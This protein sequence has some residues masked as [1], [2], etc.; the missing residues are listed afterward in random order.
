ME[1]LLVFALIAA[2][3][4]GFGAISGRIQKTV[5]TPPM[6]FVVFGLLLGEWG[7]GLVELELESEFVGV[8]AE[9]TLILVL[10]TDASR[11]DLELLRKDHDLPVRLL[12]IGLPLTMIFGTGVALV[13]FS[14]LSIWVAVVLAIILAPTDAA[15]GQA[16]VSSPK[17]PIR[18]RQA[19]NV[20]SGL[21][22][23][24]ALPILLFFLS[25][26][27]AMEAT[28]PINEWIQFGA[29]QI[30]L[31][32]VIGVAVA[33]FGG[34]LI[35]VAEHREWVAESFQKLVA[36]GLALLAFSL[37]E[38]VGG[39]GFIAAFCA[40]L[41]L[42]NMFSSV[43]GRLYEFAEA[44]GQL[45]TLLTFLLFGA[46]M[47][48]PALDHLSWQAVVYGV[49]S[50]TIIRMI[51]VALSLIGLG[52]QTQTFLFLGWFGPRGI[53]SI[54][55][56]LLVLDEVPDLPGLELMFQIVMVT[57]LISVFAHGLTAVP[58]SN[59]YG[60][61]TEAHKGDPDMPELMVVSEMP[62]RI[63]H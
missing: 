56:I 36:L 48:P 18:I 4:L 55:Y 62:V 5:I 34:R 15:L 44:E 28:R 21:N 22:D 16:V 27:G 45:L 51:P 2:F 63:R 23:G 14:E 10:F 59:R 46:I 40:G 13:L 1:E 43:C 19:L 12:A 52:L 57:V 32:P 50:L 58:A 41:T 3:I 49:L 38:L 11:I 61:N 25:L 30:I 35:S 17:V 26:A 54:L 6:I 9:F 31:G 24:I 8:L 37:A 29:S 7:L 60:D 20:E 53:A 39:N 42:G 33:Y 47:V